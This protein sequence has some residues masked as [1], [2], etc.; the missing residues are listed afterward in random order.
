MFVSL[1][2]YLGLQ[3]TCVCAGHMHQYCHIV[4][5][6]YIFKGGWQRNSVIHLPL[7]SLTPLVARV[8]RILLVKGDYKP[9]LPFTIR[10]GFR[11]KNTW[12]TNY[13]FCESISPQPVA[14][15]RFIL[16]LHG[17]TPFLCDSLLHTP[18]YYSSNFSSSDW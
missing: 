9:D 5:F 17:V 18:S 6:K 10:S 1:K 7:S 4:Y 2:F 12:S 16:W 14:V 13:Q 11:P 3:L 15:F 8:S